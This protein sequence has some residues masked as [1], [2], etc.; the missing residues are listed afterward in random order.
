[1]SLLTKL[2]VVSLFA[3]LSACGGG[4]SDG[5]TTTDGTTT[6]GTTTDGTTT[7]GTTTDGTTT[8]GTT[9]DGTTTDGTT[10]DG[11]TTDDA[12][13]GLSHIAVEAPKGDAGG[14]GIS[15]IGKNQALALSD[16]L[17]VVFEAV[18]NHGDDTG[19]NCKA[20]GA[21]F[22]SCSIINLHVK[23]TAAQLDGNDWKIYFHSIRRILRVDNTEFSIFHVNGDLHYIAPT[24][25][26]SGFGGDSVKTIKLITEFSHLH[27]TDMLPRYWLARGGNTT[28]INNTVSPTSSD[29]YGVAITGDNATAFNGEPIPV[30]NGANRFDKFADTGTLASVADIIIPTPEFSNPGSGSL[31]IGSGFSFDTSVLPAASVSALTSRQSL[32]FSGSGTPSAVST[33][34]DDSLP[35]DQYQLSIDATG[36]SITGGS[37]EAVFH[38][39][40]SLL[41]LITPGV[42]TVPFIDITDSPRFAYRGMHADISRNFQSVET[43]RSL[44]DQMAAYKLNTLHL[45]LSDD[46]GWRLAIPGLAELT[47]VGAT[48]RFQLDADGNVTEASALMPQLGSGPGSDSSATGHYTRN[49]FIELLQYAN[50]RFITVVPAFDMPGHARAAVVAMRVKAANAGRPGDTTIRLDDPEDD[51]RYLTVQHYRDGLINPCIDGTYTFIETVVTQVKAMYDE[52]GA[53]LPIW[54]MG[55]DEAKSIFKGAGFQ[56]LSEGSTIPWK[57]DIDGSL[58]D[59]PWENSPACQ[60]LIAQ[61]GSISNLADLTPYFVERL[62]TIVNDAGIEKLYAYQDIMRDVNAQSLATSTVGVNFW[63]SIT[64][65]GHT[66]AYDWP[67]KGYDT[68]I[69]V[70]DFLYFDHPYEADPKERGYYWATRYTDT[71]KVFSFMPSNLP[72]NAETSVTREGNSFSASPNAAFSGF[73]G[74]QGQIWGETVRTANQFDAM[75]FPRLLALAER[76]W[77]RADWELDYAAGTQYSQST[78]RTDRTA[79]TN[80][81][82]R[83]AN[84]LGYKELQK[85]DAANINYRISTVGV[86]SVG[87]TTTLNTEFPGQTIEYSTASEGF[88]AQV[89]D[90]ASPPV[91]VVGVRARS[92]NGARTGRSTP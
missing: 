83:F 30:A 60:N 8:E 49:Q 5:G 23:D 55:G 20:L 84:A 10:T 51:S 61:N 12:S 26:Y 28:L 77:H 6:D 27:E 53:P 22:A 79:L 76:A 1:M 3:I 91:N 65:G 81:W 92:A 70:P 9:T 50:A 48:R 64:G 25:S 66:T 59:F 17:A 80:D 73:T 14:F 7:D 69:A 75:V 2:L 4:G 40:Q 72:Q 90:A 85:L 43:I 52:A 74:M 46:E 89:Y 56:N 68:I 42:A 37:A 38:G 87:G 29:S 21:E 34:L 57:G 18:E 41:A 54:H 58:Y 11:T 33:V 82:I 39:A 88:N 63:E 32:F 44:I 86:S 62:A 36:A 78:N 13:S 47:T 31:N 16:S 35:A 71:R 45:H 19:E 67:N 24:D 15:D